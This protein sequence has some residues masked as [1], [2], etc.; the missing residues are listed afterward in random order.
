MKMVILLNNKD[1]GQFIKRNTTFDLLI[2]RLVPRKALII[3]LLKDLSY[4]L[5]GEKLKIIM[6]LVFWIDFDRYSIRP[7]LLSLGRDLGTFFAG[8]P[9]FPGRGEPFFFFFLGKILENLNIF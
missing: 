7:L 5:M 1:L 4:L 9:L 2:G 3:A 6:I 8:F